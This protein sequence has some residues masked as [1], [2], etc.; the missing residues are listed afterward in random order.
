MAS[1]PRRPLIGS[2]WAIM[3]IPS[4]TPATDSRS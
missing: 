2:G 3:V 1:K 4:V